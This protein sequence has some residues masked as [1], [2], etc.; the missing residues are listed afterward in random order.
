MDSNT[1]ATA[2]S[3]IAQ[4][5]DVVSEYPKL[6]GSF[7]ILQCF[8]WAVAILEAARAMGPI[9]NV[10]GTEGASFDI[11]IC[12]MMFFGTLHKGLI[13]DKRLAW[14]CRI[15]FLVDGVILFMTYST[16]FRPSTLE[17]ALN[18][19]A[20]GEVVSMLSGFI[21]A[22]VWLFMMAFVS[23]WIGI[24]ML[25]LAR[26]RLFE[27]AAQSPGEFSDRFVR[28]YVALIAV[29]LVVSTTV[30]VVAALVRTTEA[31]FRMSQVVGPSFNFNIMLGQVYGFKCMTFDATGQ[32]LRT[33]GKWAWWSVFFS[34]GFAISSTVALLA[35][36]L[37]GTSETFESIRAF[38]SESYLSMGCMLMVWFGIFLNMKATCL[39]LFDMDRAEARRAER[40]NKKRLYPL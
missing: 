24:R 26:R 32:T 8:C 6:V 15:A 33:A 11:A 19:T 28:V 13:S 27:Q 23:A 20:T 9:A 7:I 25:E 31:Q 40:V 4:D 35:S 1:A 37:A 14:V 21:N 2:A 10:L 16:I 3:K 22:S 34:I 5:V 39:H 12:N 18:Y 17:E 36:A 38:F 29:Q 30:T